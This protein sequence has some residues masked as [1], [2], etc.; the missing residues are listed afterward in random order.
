MQVFFRTPNGRLVARQLL[1]TLT[2]DD[3]IK[4]AGDVLG[5]T[6]RDEILSWR[7][8]VGSKP[9][10]VKNA[11]EFDKCKQHIIKE[12]NIFVLG[13]LLGGSTFPDT[14]Q[15]IVEQQL[16]DELD[17]VATHSS[18]C[19][20]CLDTDTDCLKACCVWMCSEDF[21]SWILDKQFKTSC[22]LCSKVIMLKDI[23]KSPEYIATVQALED[24]KQLLQNMDCQRC[25][26][27]NVLMHN[28]TMSS[29]QTCVKCHRLFCFFCNRNWNAATMLN[30]QNSCG[31]EC[32][33]ETMLSFQLVRF[34]YKRDMKIPSRRTCP[35]CFNFGAY[36]GKC[37][38]HSCTV[39][40]FTFCFLCLEEE[41]ECKRIHKSQYD[42]ACVRT[43]VSQTYSMFPRLVSL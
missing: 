10:D 35:R 18:E 43:P 16:E 37:K 2:L 6:I 32:V 34:H 31:K 5:T 42:H 19:S 15:T 7:Y 23:F 9:L 27:C 11:K 33:Y 14:L 21:K 30:R 8:T 26:N 41:N 17:K 40:K 39:C 29:C 12:C 20:I 36:D 25:L 38:Y 1:D 4:T 22:I 24:E 3:F 13:R 28:E